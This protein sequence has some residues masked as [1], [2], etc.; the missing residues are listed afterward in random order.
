MKNDET[1]AQ[2]LKRLHREA[3][4]RSRLGITIGDALEFRRE[5]YDLTAAE[6]AGVLGLAKSHYSELI[7]G[8]RAL[9]SKAMKRA[10]AVGVPASVL[11]QP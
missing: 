1:K 3:S 11:L 6:F 9:P 10:F 4:A 7:H 2:R 5:C 8:K